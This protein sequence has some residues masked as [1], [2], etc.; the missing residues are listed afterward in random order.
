MHREQVLQEKVN[1][2]LCRIEKETI[3]QGAKNCKEVWRWEGKMQEL[4]SQKSEG[5]NEWIKSKK[6]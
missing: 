4:K 5:M 3:E 1:C 6:Q 2:T